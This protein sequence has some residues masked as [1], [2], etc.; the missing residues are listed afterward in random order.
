[1]I[2]KE[3]RKRSGLKV[4]KIALELGVSR[5]HYYQ[6]EKGNTKLTKDKIEVLSKLFNVS[7]KEIRDGVKMEEVFELEKKIYE[8]LL[9]SK[10][11]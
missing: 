2:L 11:Q 10:K 4:S 1:M 3:I 7:K 8:L 5:E 9:K 6:L